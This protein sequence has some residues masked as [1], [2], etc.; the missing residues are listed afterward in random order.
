MG[1]KDSTE[2]RIV[3]ASSEPM[4]RIAF[5]LPSAVAA[6]LLGAQTAFAQPTILTNL[7]S[8]CN[9][10]TGELAAAC[11]P[12]FIGHL[13][14]TVFSI[15]S[16]F[17]LINV[18]IAG[19]QIAMGAWTGEKSAGKDRLF[20]SIAGLVI[21]VSVFLLLDLALTVISP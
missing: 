10:I 15:L 1:S 9:F 5:P 13:V 7:G 20:W 3:A 11:I 6:L 17:F 14:T 19:Y 2:M 16:I 21:S 12:R 8:D 18:M 4:H